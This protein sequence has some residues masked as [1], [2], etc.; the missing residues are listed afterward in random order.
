MGPKRA[1][2]APDVPAEDLIWQD[3]VPAGPTGYDVAAVKARIAASGLSDC[4]PGQHRLGQR[5]T[6]RGSDKRGGANGARIRLAPQR[7]GPATAAR[8]PGP[9]A[10]GAGADRRRRRRQCGR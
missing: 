5:P 3:P 4:R 2:L 1:T 9:R 7:T 6:F 10:G 8:A